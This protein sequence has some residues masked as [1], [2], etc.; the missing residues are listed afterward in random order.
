MYAFIQL[1][2][3]CL[4]RLYVKLRFFFLQSYYVV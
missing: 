4:T 1:H 2:L 3:S